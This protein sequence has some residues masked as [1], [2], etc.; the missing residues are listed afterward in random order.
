[1]IS[2]A[3]STGMTRLSNQNAEQLI[4]TAIRSFIKQFRIFVP[5]LKERFPKETRD[6]RQHKIPAHLLAAVLQENVLRTVAIAAVFPSQKSQ[7]SQ[8]QTLG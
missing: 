2:L 6:M 5:V 7:N 8:D 4:I 3:V 1:M